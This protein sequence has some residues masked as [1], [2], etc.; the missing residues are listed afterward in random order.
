MAEVKP[1]D[2][3]HHQPMDQLQGFEYCIDSNPS[4]GMYVMSHTTLNWWWSVAVFIC[5]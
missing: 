3:V 4:W 2:M 1:E 5:V